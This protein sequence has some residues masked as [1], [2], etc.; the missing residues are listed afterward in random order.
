MKLKYLL[1]GLSQIEIKGSKEIEI[2]GISS[3]SRTIAPGNLFIAKKGGVFDGTQFINRAIDSGA[4]AVLTDFYDPFLKIVQLITHQPHLYEAQLASQY[5]QNPSEDLLV[6]GVTGSKGKT[7]TTY[8]IQHLVEGLG[9]KCG[10]IGTIETKIG[11][12]AFPSNFT[13][14]DI[15]YNQKILREMLLKKCEAV[16]F[17][18]SS[19]GLAQGRVEKIDFDFAVFTNLYPDHLD[20]H[21]TMENYAAAK[22]KLFLNSKSIILNGDS[23]WSEFMKGDQRAFLFGIENKMDLYASSIK[24][25]SHGMTFW[26]EFEGK[27]QKIKTSLMGLFN[28]Y[29]LL[30]AISVGLQLGYNL[31]KI[32]EV[33]SDFTSVPGRL[34]LVDEKQEIKVFVDHAHT[35]DALEAALVALRPIV[36]NKLLVV[37]GCGGDR[38]PQR[39]QGMARSAEKWADIS[40]ITNDNPRSEDPKEICQQILSGFQGR[41]NVEVELDRKKAIEH[42]IRIA[43]P[44]DVILIAGKGHEKV[45]IFSHQA[46]FFDDV[47]VAKMA[48]N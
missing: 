24:S 15:V 6:I 37:F 12:H 11:D 39:R 14:H 45:Q 26:V 8:L 31:E 42:A 16:A 48:L 29:N 38:D 20:Y 47:V 18:V 1:K 13:T 22:K 40:I 36:K 7:T 35:G 23:P 44:G 19:H 41:E 10:L 28:V 46:L 25:D 3:D 9:K 32:S 5:Y 4:S 34:Q 33:L 30:G 2:T 27:K 43:E 21:Q 17:E